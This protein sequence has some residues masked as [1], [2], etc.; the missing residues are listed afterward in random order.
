MPSLGNILLTIAPYVI[1]FVVA[2]VSYIIFGLSK[3]RKLFRFLGVDKSS[4][5]VIVYLSSLLIPRGGAAGFNGQPR[6]YHGIAIP[7]EELGISSRLSTAFKLDPFKNIPPIIRKPLQD[8]YAFFRP[9]TVNITGSP[10]QERKIDFSTR[11]MIT[12]GSQGYN[13]VT[14]YCV[15]RN[16]SQLEITHNGT[17]IEIMKGKNQGEVIQPVSNQHDIAILERLIDRTRNDT[18]IIIAAGL[19]VVGTMGAIQ[20]L[21]DHWRKI[22]KEYRNREFALVLQF[23]LSSAH[24]LEETLKGTVIRQLPPS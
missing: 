9:L 13:V 6:S 4:R 2:F 11:S 23:G 1:G 8:K 3:Q 15:S 22:E 21:I 19:G 20:H 17:A 10:M 24:N 16:L 14:N 12:V 7:S 5:Q 18:T